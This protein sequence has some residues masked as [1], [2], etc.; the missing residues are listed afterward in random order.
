MNEFSLTIDEKTDPLRVKI[1]R[2]IE[3]LRAH[4]PAEGYYF[5]DSY[6]KDSCVCLKLLQMSGVKFDAHH[7][8]T[9]VDPPELI[10]FGKK[11]HTETEIH[12]PEKSMFQLIADHYFLPTQ[13]KRFCCKYFKE[14]GGS[15][16][17]TVTGIRWAESNKRAKRRMT[18]VCQNDTTKIYLHPIIDW[19]TQDVWQFIKEYK[20]PYCS[21]YD[22]GFHRLGC[23]MC[24]MQRTKGML[25]DAQRWPK[26]AK[27][28]K[29]AAKRYLES[30]PN[31]GLFQY[32]NTADEA[33][34]WWIFRKS[35][36]RIEPD[37]LL[38]FEDQ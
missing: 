31:S 10:E 14:S 5:A 12:K 36:N 11:Y 17:L 8:F 33:Y 18:E 25:R 23:I 29:L 34:H 13:L 22:E 6:G 30:H 7:S 21:L 24:P 19:S 3:R 27:A 15:G 4:E 35:T 1:E 2:S 38:P 28:Y 32:F 20:I 26:Y 16:R 37:R 9:T